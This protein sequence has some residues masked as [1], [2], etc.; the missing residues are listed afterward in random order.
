V[1]VT[2]I[3]ES[4]RNQHLAASHEVGIIGRL[5]RDLNSRSIRHIN[6]A[7]GSKYE[8]RSLVKIGQITD[9]AQ[10]FPSFVIERPVERKCH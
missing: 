9:C 1:S 4:E 8:Y 5:V 3:Q 10:S 7:V 2:L 6:E